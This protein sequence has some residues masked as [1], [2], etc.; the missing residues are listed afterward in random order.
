MRRVPTGIHG[1]DEIIEG[2]FIE[3]SVILVSGGPGAGKSIFG[4]Q[5]IYRGAVDGEPGIY[6]TFEEDEESLKLIARRLGMDFDKLGNVAIV[7]FD[8]LKDIEEL[9]KDISK[10]VKKYRAK[11]LV[12]DA[13][14][15]IELFSTTFKSV[16]SEF[17]FSLLSKGITITPPYEAIERR[18]IYKLVKALKSMGITAVLIAEEEEMDV[19]KNHVTA[20]IVDGVI[21]LEMDMLADLVTRCMYIQK[22][23][24]TKINS[25]RLAME[26]TDRGI[27]VWVEDLEIGVKD[28]DVSEEEG[29]EEEG[30]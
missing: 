13:I 21:R 15:S 5:F 29:G 17:P 25:Y 20:F 10:L 4:L 1:L 16:I 22:L 19:K 7:K 6:I 27:E 26:I 9:I 12:I 24:A 23:R 18:A 28:S 3:G 2:G 11:R 14:S 30:S 8:P